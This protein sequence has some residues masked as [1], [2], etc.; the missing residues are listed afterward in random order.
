MCLSAQTRRFSPVAVRLIKHWPVP[1]RASA[2]LL[3][4]FF[5]FLA[6]VRH[7]TMPGP[8]PYGARTITVELYDLNSKQRSS[9]ACLMSAYAVQVPSGHRMVPGRC[10]FTLNDPTTSRMG[11]VEF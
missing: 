9:G 2:E 5:K 4:D 6:L 3:R 1:R 10:H 8:A 7:R 11:A